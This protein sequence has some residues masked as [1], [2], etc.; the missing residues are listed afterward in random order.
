MLHT[1]GNELRE[2]ALRRFNDEVVLKSL[3]QLVTENRYSL[4]T[5]K[6]KEHSINELKGPM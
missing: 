4:Y 3:L 1:F 6:V 5:G 2:S